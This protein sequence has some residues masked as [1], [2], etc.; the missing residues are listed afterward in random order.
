[1]PVCKHTELCEAV[2]E[3]MHDT[4]CSVIRLLSMSF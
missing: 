3:G 1:M 2:R 4:D